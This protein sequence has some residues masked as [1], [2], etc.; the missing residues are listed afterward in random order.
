MRRTLQHPG[1]FIFRSLP[2]SFGLFQVTEQS[3]QASSLQKTQTK[4]S[5]DKVTSVLAFSAYLVLQCYI[6]EVFP[7]PQA[8]KSPHAAL[9][10]MPTSLHLYPLKTSPW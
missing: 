9:Q 5:M 10:T 4:G 7:S 3:L 2:G 6:P 1:R 8:S